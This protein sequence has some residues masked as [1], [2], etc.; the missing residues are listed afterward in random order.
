[1]S[2]KEA[3]AKLKE[4]L[5]IKKQISPDYTE[6]TIKYA[7]D[8]MMVH[9]EDAL[10]LLTKEQPP[11]SEFTKEKRRYFTVLPEELCD[12]LAQKTARHCSLTIQELCDRLDTSEAAIKE[13][14]EV[15]DKV[16]DWL[17]TSSLQQV[18]VHYTEDK[19]KHA[20]IMGI[21]SHLERLEAVITKHKKE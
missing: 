6:E 2:R 9:I 14:V 13:L 15:C 4:A 19:R 16:R 21:A 18:L 10:Q 17:D 1:M 12:S 8:L 5:E 7:A 11:A 20:L 3:I